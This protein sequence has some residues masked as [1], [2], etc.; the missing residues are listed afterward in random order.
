MTIMRKPRFTQENNTDAGS[1]EEPDLY[2]RREY[3][4]FR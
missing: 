2:E 3:F 4:C 1:I